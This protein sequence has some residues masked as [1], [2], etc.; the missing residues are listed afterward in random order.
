MGFA[1]DVAQGRAT[2]DARR[3]PLPDRRTPPSYPRDRSRCRRRTERGR[4]RC[5]RRRGRRPARCTSGRTSPPGQR[6]P[7]RRN[8]RSGR[9]ASGRGRSRCGAPARSPRH[10]AGRLF[11][12]GSRPDRRWLPWRSANPSD[13]S[14]SAWSWGA[15]AGAAAASSPTGTEDVIDRPAGRFDRKA[16]SIGGQ[17]SHVTEL[18]RVGAAEV[19]VIRFRKPC[20]KSIVR[21]RGDDLAFNSPRICRSR[22]SPG[23]A[24]LHRAGRRCHGLDDVGRNDAGPGARPA[25][26][27]L[28]RLGI[29]GALRQPPRCLPRRPGGRRLHRGAQRRRSSTGGP[30]ASTAGCRRWPR[31]W[32]AVRWPSSWRR[33]APRSCWRQK[34]R[35][36]GC[37]SSSR[38]A[39]IPSRSA[40]W[41]ACPGPAATSPA[42][43]ASAWRSRASGW[44]S[45]ARC[46]PAAKRFAIAINPHEPD[47]GVAT[48][49]PRG[50]GA[51]PRRRA[52]RAQGQRR[53]RSS[54]ACSPPYAG[55]GRRR[56]GLQLRSLL[57]LPQPAA[58]RARGPPQGGRDHAIARLSRSPAG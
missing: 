34:R 53:S 20:R 43:R 31:S 40:S 38:W 18:A 47:L 30:T 10:R 51:Q 29:A 54:T 50:R 21:W 56:T 16:A 23:A 4:R 41:R 2:L 57:R 48:E 46:G 12:P 44:S 52:H 13:P 9:D 6:R 36:R 33:A 14:M 35:R 25:G 37:R 55:C 19:I 32:Q 11:R 5:G 39:A 26:H 22:R 7:C 27:R 8:G 3:A 58:G 28:S 42:C 49:E 15:P 17:R 45:C 1:V 24:R